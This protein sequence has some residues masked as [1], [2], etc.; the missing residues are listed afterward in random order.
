MT[1]LQRWLDEISNTR[2]LSQEQKQ[3]LKDL[4]RS[5]ATA[6]GELGPKDRDRLRAAIDRAQ[7]QPSSSNQ[8]QN[9]PGTRPA[10]GGPNPAP[11]PGPGGNNT[12]GNNPGGNN[13]GG[14]NDRPPKPG[15][16]WNWDGSRW[17][18]PPKPTSGEH[19]WDDNKG[20]VKS[21]SQGGNDDRPPKPG[22]AWVWSPS[23]NKW[24][25]PPSPG[26]GEHTWD[27]NKGWVK[28]PNSPGSAWVWEGQGGS[29][30]WKKPPM[31]TDGKQ[32]TWDD[33]RGW[34]SPEEEEETE[35]GGSPGDAWVWD[36]SAGRWTRPE[37]PA[38]G[39]EYTW[40]DD[41]GWIEDVP[42]DDDP[43]PGS[44]E[45]RES[46][47]EFFRGLLDQFGFNVGDIDGLMGLF[48]E[49]ISE[50]FDNDAIMMKFRGTD[51]YARRFPGMK[52]LSNRGQAITEGEYIRLESAYRAN[53]SKYGLPTE[54]YDS[55][56]DYGKFIENN[57]SP[58]EVDER[59]ATGMRILQSADRR[60]LT[61]LGEY[62]GV[63]QGT[64][65]AYL[66]DGAKGQDLI[67]R[68]VRAA[69]IGGTGERYKFNMDRTLSE[70]LAT[71]ALGQ[72]IDGMSPDA[73]ARLDQSFTT[74]RKI[75]D[76]ERVLADIDSERFADTD[77]ARAMFGDLDKQLASQKRASRERSRFLGSSGVGAGSLGQERN[78]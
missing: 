54:F 67:Q 37:R 3:S 18:K 1:D 47:S 71:T 38:D 72:S 49:W 35:P 15:A 42:V 56:D 53:L 12:G 20:W 14:N 33:T 73:A 28:R 24:I 9:T 62:Y 69:T 25:K 34:I 29:G 57:I 61:E 39:K 60:I 36:E 74:A 26:D 48:D 22:A 46:A 32:Y 44:P 21:P 70:D 50:G 23:T 6:K 16:A 8:S 63:T 40:D 68:Q 10:S 7:A 27:D 41:G 31:P 66:L 78:F 4:A 30:S 13:Q 5:L 77:A 64:A 45:S 52:A 59:A 11:S 51:V 17:V 55:P 75:A 2:G 65:L 43:L 19:T 76:R 58:D